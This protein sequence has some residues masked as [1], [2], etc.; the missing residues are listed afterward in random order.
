MWA[1]REKTKARTVEH[2]KG[3]RNKTLPEK[4]ASAWHWK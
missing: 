4:K 1:P 2:R 3:S